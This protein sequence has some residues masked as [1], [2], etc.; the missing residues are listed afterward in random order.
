[1]PT[2]VYEAMNQGGSQVKDDIEAA[3]SEDAL[4]KIRNLGY[5]PTRIREK[6]GARGKTASAAK[7][8][9]GGGFSFGG[10]PQKTI[11]QMTRQLST[12]QDA[13]LPILRSLNI[14]EEQQKPG[15][16]KNVLR[17]MAEDI[18]GGATLS[19]A[20]AKHPNAFHRLYVN[21]VSAGETGGV[22]DVILQRLA[23]FM[24]KAEK[25][26]KK[27]Q[28]AMVYPIVVVSFSMSIVA[29]IMIVV[30]PEFKKA[31]RKK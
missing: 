15:T 28:G 27:I 8:K 26:K 10:V 12:L 14:L 24:E 6:G 7:K 29:G 31:K 2:F 21:M 23:E 30:I 25:L 11:T 4:A 3:S 20:C 19:E 9:R 13:G 22:L 5:F 16:M 18:E 1:M 17:G